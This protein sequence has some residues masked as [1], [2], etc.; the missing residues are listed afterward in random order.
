[1][2]NIQRKFINSGITP[3]LIWSFARQD[4]VERYAGSAL[5][6]AWAFLQPIVMMFI[7]IVIFGQL[8][9]S[10]LPGVETYY[11]Y[12]IFLIAGMIPWIAFS[13]TLTRTATVFVDKKNV[14]SKVRISLIVF[15]IFILLAETIIFCIG[16]LIFGCF[17]IYINHIPSMNILAMPWIFL[18]QQMLA[19][20][21][22]MILGVLNVFIRDVKEFCSIL[23]QLLFWATPI[24]WS[25]QVMTID[26]YNWL[27][28]FNPLSNIISGYQS[29]F[30][31]NLRLDFILLNWA[32]GIGA[33]TLAVGFLL[34][35]RMEKD[36]RDLI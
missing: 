8:M 27:K 21:L 16:F 22:G 18:I 36:I 28:I 34:V 20:G 4:L 24:V 33:I 26:Q 15:P 7:F 25:P 9:N 11:G 19:T 3:A 10:R 35:H 6:F 32:A 31:G 12:S 30:L 5:G 14:L 2:K 13:N 23:I 29:I 17:L 1:M